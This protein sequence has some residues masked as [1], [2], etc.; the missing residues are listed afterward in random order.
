MTMR[1][2][3]LS[4]MQALFIYNAATGSLQILFTTGHVFLIGCHLDSVDILIA[5][6][7]GL[8]VPLSNIEEPCF[9]FQCLVCR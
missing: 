7:S 3:E 5:C 1:F 2:S 9:L 6:S 4:M 8:F